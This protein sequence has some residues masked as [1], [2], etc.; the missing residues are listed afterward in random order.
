MSR[1][2][3]AFFWLSSVLAL[4]LLVRGGEEL[5][6]AGP[7]T[8]DK[9]DIPLQT[10]LDQLAAQ[11]KI[12]VLNNA[13][14]NP[15]LKLKVKKATFWEA[16]DR[17]ATAADA[18]LDLY[19]P[20]G[21]IALVR[22]G[23]DKKSLLK[24]QISRSGPF[25]VSLQRLTAH[26]DFATGTR[27]SNALFELAWEPSVDVFYMQSQPQK[28]VIRD[29]K[30]KAVEAP[31]GSKWITLDARRAITFDVDLPSLPRSAEQMGL[32]RGTIPIRGPSRM[33]TFRFP[34]PASKEPTLAD[35]SAHLQDANKP[36]EESAGNKLTSC[37]LQ[38]VTLNSD[39]WRVRITTALPPGGPDFET[40]E[41]WYAFNEVYLQSLDGKTRLAWTGYA[42]ESAGTQKAVVSY[43]FKKPAKGQR[44][45]AKDWMLVVRAPA[46]MIEQSV[47]FE[48]KDVPLP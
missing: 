2:I 12:V 23:R 19:R 24:P 17:I 37:A 42:Q 1:C 9:E 39:S 27:A 11:S 16:L 28:L 8:I 26:T 41:T 18:Q 32:L 6:G 25:R 35:L 10:A 38:R 21:R 7:V 36:L 20:D 5:P 14:D 44:D 13:G 43:T 31:T 29:D 47:P 45:S 48:F 4:P 15:E 3:L 40:H 22:R 46:S 33:H 34:T 30:G